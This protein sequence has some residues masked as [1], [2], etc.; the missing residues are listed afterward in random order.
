VAVFVALSEFSRRKFIAGGL[1]ADRVLVKPNFLMD[2]PG[3]GRHAGSFALFVGRLSAEKGLATLVEAWRRLGAPMPL[4]IAGAGPLEP[5][6]AEPKPGIEWVGHASPERVRALMRDATLL[7]FPSECYENCPITLL[8]AFACGLPTVASGHG[9]IGEMVRAPELGLLFRPG[10][11]A[12][13]AEILAGA[14][15]DAERLT[16]MGRAAR[17]EFETRYS[18]QANLPQ[19]MAIYAR[20]IE[21]P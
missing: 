15:S 7:V 20:A 21:D 18:P 1:P 3:V 8:E 10:D 11:P 6:F 2:D 17:A 4:R 5:M 13:L 9:S 14:L 16:R 12:H 19:L